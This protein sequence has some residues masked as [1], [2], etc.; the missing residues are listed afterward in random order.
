MAPVDKATLTNGDQF[1]NGTIDEDVLTIDICLCI[2][3]M[4]SS[5]VANDG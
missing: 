5:C 2:L 4:C 3:N 1:T